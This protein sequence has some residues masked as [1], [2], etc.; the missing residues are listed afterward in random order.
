MRLRPAA[1]AFLLLTAGTSAAM[2]QEAPPAAANQPVVVTSGMPSEFADLDQAQ[3]LVADV[4]FGETRIGQFNIESRPGQVRFA[5]PAKV[6]AA[7]PNLID[8]DALAQALTG[9]LD[10]NARFLCTPASSPCEV[11][12]PEVAAI[13]F[14]P[15]RFRIDLY[16]NSRLL[17][18]RATVIDPY[19]RPHGKGLSF[20]DILGGA[21]AGGDGQT[22][23]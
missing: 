23:S 13:V 17:S 2:A 8:A 3:S 1:P 15:Q 7:I 18:V 16:L 12:Q 4:F 10:A 6:A 14:D 21:V 22:V 20:V 11:P 5:D 19:L 9:T